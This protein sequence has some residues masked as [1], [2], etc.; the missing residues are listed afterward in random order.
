MSPTLSP[1][2]R[3]VATDLDGT[4][5]DPQGRVSARA[6]AAVRFARS[7]GIEVL[8]VTARAPW[9]MREIAAAAG[10]GDLAV[11]GNGAVLYD[12]RAG[13]VLEHLPLSRDLAIQLVRAVRK[14]L[15]GIVFASENIE[16]MVSER[17][18]LDAE[19]A[20][21]WGLDSRTM[22]PDVADHLR[23]EVSVSKLL[24]HHPDRPAVAHELVV[25][26]VAGACGELAS[27]TSAG[28]GWITIGAPGVTK[29]VGLAKAC[30][31]LGISAGEVA[32]VGDALNDVPML[33]WVG[34]PV[35]VSNA[36]P[37]VLALASRVL[38]SN[39]EDGVAQLLE[40]LASAGSRSGPQVSSGSEVS[41]R[42]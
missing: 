27:V 15:P 35:A 41:S 6:A 12:C 5:L 36:C 32:C 30:E 16:A 28:P 39:A 22:V 38:P 11:C 40:E 19:A 9:A 8:A 18:L 42:G 4:F 7:Q 23:G 37:E 2:V 1:I 26:L 17:G 13:E 33:A 29:A 20:A 24:C 25:E 31:R 10:M 34:T 3:L 21:T 14:V